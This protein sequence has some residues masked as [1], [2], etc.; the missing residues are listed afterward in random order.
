MKPATSCFYRLTMKS[1]PAAFE[2]RALGIV[3]DRLLLTPE[4]CKQQD[5]WKRNAQQPQ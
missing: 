1:C 5:H 3:S 2:R 4:Q